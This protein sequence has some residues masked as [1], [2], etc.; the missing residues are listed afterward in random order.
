MELTC[1]PVFD[2]GREPAEWTLVDGSRHVADASGAGLTIRLQTDLALGI[3]GDRVRARHVLQQG[4]QL[5]CALSWAE[6]LAAPADVDEANEQL[7]ATVASGARWLGRARDPR[8]PLA[9]P[10]PALGAGDQG[11]HLHAHRRHRRGAHD[12]AAGDAR[13]RAQLGLPLHVA[14]R[15]DLHAA[16]AAL[17]EPRLGGRGVHAVRRRPR[18]QQ[19]R[20]PADHVRDRRPPRSDRVDPR[21]P[22]RLRRGAARCGSATAPSTSARTTSSAPRSTRSCCTRGAAS[23]CRAGCGRSCRRR[24]NARP[25][26]GASPTRASG[27]RAASPSTTSPRSSCAGWR[28]TAPRS[29]RRSAATTSSQ[30]SGQRRREEIQRGHPRPRRRASDGVLRQHYETDALDASNLL[31]AIFGFLP[32]DDERLR[33]SVLAIADELTEDGFVLRYRTDETDDGLSG[34]EGSFLICSFW[35]VSALAII[36]EEQRARDLMERL[37]RVASPLGLYAEEFDTEHRPPPR[38]LPAGVLPP[39][40]DRGRRSAHHP[41]RATARSSIVSSRSDR[42]YDVIIIGSGAGGG[43]LARHLAPSGKR[44]LLLERG[45]W[46]PREPQN[47][48]RRGGVRGRTAT[49]RRTPGTTRRQAVPA[50]GPL[51]RRA[52]PR[53]STARRCTGCASEDFGELRHHDGIS[54]A[55]PISY[56]E[57]EPYYT[58]AEQ[59]YQ[60]HGARGEDPTE[61]PRERALSVPGRLARAAHPAAL[62]RL[63]RRRASIRSTPPAG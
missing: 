15:L 28:W 14:A 1:E 33:A 49:S 19:G 30:R 56:E 7:A 35:L 29:S 16:G 52:A 51:L 41:R 43:T 42:Y 22:L 62:R 21:R 27:R 34:K 40:A 11:P 59:L 47:W 8:P 18:A 6:G 54:P 37:L 9:R 3:E 13:R 45:D 44:I 5:Y 17:L 20:R 26:S 32:G 10:D 57:M 23:G 61:P 36:G 2:Y 31:A 38:Q 12:L 50:A 25:R 39:G 55:W 24:P 60:V 53:S 4:E 48:L 63:R 58:Q 46:L